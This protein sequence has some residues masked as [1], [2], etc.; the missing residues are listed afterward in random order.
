ML[1][2]RFGAPGTVSHKGRGNVVTAVDIAAERAAMTVLHAEYPAIPVLGEESG[3]QV[4]P[5]RGWTWIV[6]PIDGTRNF[7]SSV[8]HFSTV[9]ALAHDGEVMAGVTH[10]PIRRETFHAVRG[11]GAFLNGSPIHATTQEH[12]SDGILGMDLSYSD[13]GAAA[14]LALVQ[15]LWPGMQTVRIL[16]SAALGLAYV[17]AG[18]F[19]AFFHHK[20]EPWDQA[21]GLLLVAEAGGIVTDRHGTP[22]RLASDGTIAAGR[23]LHPEFMK[24]IAGSRWASSSFPG[25]AGALPTSAGPRPVIHTT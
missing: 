19:H 24:L 7:A 17:A 8:P 25:Q 10:D 2:E 20:L 14:Q 21:A 12:L 16:G 6:D 11:R 5:N 15:D 9:I 3:G 23:S 1:A 18:R 13:D 4:D 22:A